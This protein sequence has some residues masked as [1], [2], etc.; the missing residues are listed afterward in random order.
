MIEIF[1]YD[2][3]VVVLNKTECDVNQNKVYAQKGHYIQGGATPLVWI[4]VTKR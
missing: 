1:S 4:I 2:V 3:A